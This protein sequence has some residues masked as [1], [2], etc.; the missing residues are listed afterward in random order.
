VF[1]GTHFPSCYKCSWEIGP[2]NWILARWKIRSHISAPPIPPPPTKVVQGPSGLPPALPRSRGHPHHATPATPHGGAALL[3]PGSPRPR[4]RRQPL[5]RTPRQ[6]SV[7]PLRHPRTHS[8]GHRTCV[9]AI[10]PSI[11]LADDVP[12]V[13]HIGLLDSLSDYEC[14]QIYVPCF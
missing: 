10:L 3:R 4:P 6:P 14:N 9:L 8:T 11:N 5:Q 13:F 7:D 2:D 1:V 12:M